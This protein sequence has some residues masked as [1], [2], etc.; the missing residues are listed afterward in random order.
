[1][2]VDMQRKINFLYDFCSKYKLT[3]N[4]SKTKMMVFRNGGVIKAIEKWTYGGVEIEPVTY[5][6]YLG[7]TMSSRLCWSTFL[8]NLTNKASRIVNSARG[9]FNRYKYI[10][11]KTAFKIFD[12]KIKPILL[13][14]SE[15]WGFGYHESMKYVS[16]R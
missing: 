2:I 4:Q 7:V 14:G 16:S 8:D 3:V 15:V 12:M 9:F 5:Y 10:D 11:V 13:Y 1:M 6:P